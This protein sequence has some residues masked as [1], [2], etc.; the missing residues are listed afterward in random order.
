MDY[1]MDPD[2]VSHPTYSSLMDDA[3]LAI[4]T[5]RW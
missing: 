5:C 1:G 4:P 2:I 3:L